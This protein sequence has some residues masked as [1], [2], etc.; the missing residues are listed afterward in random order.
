MH[1]GM[2]LDELR[3]YLPAPP[4]APDFDSF[5]NET[6]A[7]NMKSSIIEMTKIQGPYTE[8]DAYDV[9]VAGFNGDP[10]KGWFITPLAL[11][12]EVPCIV[13]FEGY[14]GGRGYPH[15]WLFW[16]SCGYA[17]LVM[18]TRAQ[19]RGHRFGES[20]DGAYPVGNHSPGFMTMGVEDPYNYFYRR[21]YTDAVCFIE[22]AAKLPNVDASRIVTA[23][24]SQGG[25]IAIAATGLSNKVFAAMP[26]V[27]FLCH[28]EHATKI[29]DAY[30]YQEIV[31]YLRGDRE[32][33]SQI[34][35]TLAYFDGINFARKAK[36]PALFSVGLH[37]PICPPETVFAAFNHWQGSKQIEIWPYSTHEG[38]GVV[39]NLK[40]AQW[41]SN[42]LKESA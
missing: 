29:T 18:D 2:P 34:F 42:L 20:P 25:G 19:G 28:M 40:Q 33:V 9:T 10:I 31:N 11:D 27:P 38:G 26:D 17:A 6:L 7:D 13:I 30:P 35:H 5:W 39:Q 16:P 32:A 1:I 8:I 14:G 15:E 4:V 23:G 24:A 36:V 12:A 3:N 41:L 37:D 22:A 21:V